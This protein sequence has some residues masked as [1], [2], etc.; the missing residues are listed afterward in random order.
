VMVIEPAISEDLSDNVLDL[1]E[2]PSGISLT[3]YNK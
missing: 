3:L 2:T 1:K